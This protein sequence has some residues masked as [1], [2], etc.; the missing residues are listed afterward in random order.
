MLGLRNCKN[1]STCVYSGLN[2]PSLYIVT[3]TMLF[4][5]KKKIF[6]VSLELGSMIGLIIYFTQVLQRLI[7]LLNRYNGAG[8][9]L[10]LNRGYLETSLWRYFK[11][12]V[13]A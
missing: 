8:I 11:V 7:F 10:E 12:E 9:K 1:R 5:I 2:F 6:G 4:I 13:S 3:L